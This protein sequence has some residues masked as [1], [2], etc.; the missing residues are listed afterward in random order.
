MVDLVHVNNEKP[1]TLISMAECLDVD[2]LI[3]VNEFKSIQNFKKWKEDFSKIKSPINISFGVELN[4]KNVNDLENVLNQIR[5]DA[6]VIIVNG[7]NYDINRA[8]SENDKV[9]ILMHPEEDRTDRG[10]DEYTCKQAQKNGIVIG[11]SFRKIMETYKKSRA[12]KLSF[13][14]QNIN[15]LKSE[16]I[17]IVS[18]AYSKWEMRSP[19]N[20]DD[21]LLTLTKKR[22]KS[23]ANIEGKINK[24]K[25]KLSQ[26]HEG[27]RKV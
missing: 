14:T 20:M 22:V 1:E 13:I 7:G 6:D 10:M 8:A 4:P 9:D 11:I 24:N 15:L 25:K 3:L 2:H 19:R 12:F 23:S 17:A 18:D 21:F 26:I 5:K 27:V 16:N